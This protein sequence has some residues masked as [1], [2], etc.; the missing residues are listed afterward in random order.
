M[1]SETDFYELLKYCPLDCPFL[2]KKK[3]TYIFLC[4]TY[5]SFLEIESKNARVK[6]FRDCGNGVPFSEYMSFKDLLA[7]LQKN[8]PLQFT[9]KENRLLENLFLALD[10][11]EQVVMKHVLQTASL[12]IPFVKKVEREVLSDDFLLS[13]RQVLKSYSEKEL[14]QDPSLQLKLS[15]LLLPSKNSGQ[16]DTQV[17]HQLGRLIEMQQNTDR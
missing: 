1:A 13:M 8:D 12:T 3:D 4:L 6:R 14:S 7:N 9:Q 5:R 2:R 11:V 17:N 16:D 10:R 15:R